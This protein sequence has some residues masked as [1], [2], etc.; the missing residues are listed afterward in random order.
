MY[1]KGVYDARHP[2]NNY[3]L[4]LVGVLAQRNKNQYNQLGLSR[5]KILK[6]EKRVIT[7][8]GLDAINGTPVL[9][10]KPYIKQ[11]GI[12]EIT[13]QPEWVNEIMKD[14]Y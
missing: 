10:V 11:F 12:T 9:D 6:V 2:R 13:K 4:P 8:K 14:Y 1:C 7:L 3:N 5:A